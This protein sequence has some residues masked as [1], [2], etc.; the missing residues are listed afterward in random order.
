MPPRLLPAMRFMYSNP[1]GRGLFRLLQGDAILTRM[2]LSKGLQMDSPRSAPDIPGFLGTFHGQLNLSEVALPSQ[3]TISNKLGSCS[4]AAAA[5]QFQ[6]STLNSAAQ[7][8][9]IPSND[10]T[11]SSGSALTA[12]RHSS[13]SPELPDPQPATGSLSATELARAF[14]TFNHFFFRG[15]R[16]GSRPVAAA[17]D[18][19]VAVSAADCRLI[20]Y[21]SVQEAMQVGQ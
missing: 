11:L 5:S 9:I 19:R 17:Q 12:A 21:E 16:P 15:L 7:D 14:P 20:A 13:S 18:P 3:P 8:V 6:G 1:L 2:T 4:K 10:T